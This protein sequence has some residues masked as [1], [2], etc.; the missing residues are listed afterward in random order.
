MEEGSTMEGRND[1]DERRDKQ[2]GTDSGGQ[3]V[4]RLWR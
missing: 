3:T 2:W 4:E 1:H